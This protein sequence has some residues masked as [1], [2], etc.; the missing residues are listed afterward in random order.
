MA[1]LHVLR[2]LPADVHMVLMTARL[3]DSGAVLDGS[4]ETFDELVSFIDEELGA[5]IASRSAVRPLMA[6]CLRID[7]DCANWIGT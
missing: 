6:L 3:T 2:G 4:E 7:P 5:G 1:A